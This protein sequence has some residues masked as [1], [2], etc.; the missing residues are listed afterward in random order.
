M[1]RAAPTLASA[2][3]LPRSRPPT[4][5][6]L[7]ARAWTPGSP[8]LPAAA[9]EP[10]LRTPQGCALQQRAHGWSVP[11]SL[12]SG[13]SRTIASWLLQNWRY[14]FVD[15][16][17]SCCH[18]VAQDLPVVQEL[19]SPFRLE[20]TEGHAVARA[21]LMNE[22][23]R[24][25]AAVVLA[26]GQVTQLSL[27]RRMQDGC[28]WWGLPSVQCD[29]C[30][31]ACLYQLCV[32]CSQFLSS[33]RGSRY[34]WYPKACAK[35]SCARRSLMASWRGRCC[36]GRWLGAPARPGSARLPA[37]PP[38]RSPRAMLV[39]MMMIDDWLHRLSAGMA[40]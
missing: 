2:A 3:A 4:W 34:A 36:T 12:A 40:V 35:A 38:T 25:A 18:N 23:G 37:G 6:L 10:V 32:L 20:G 1:E 9:G 27:I 5:P 30:T 24:W 13:T 29:V 15:M 28:A 14:A 19:A 16:S 39:R 11:D 8:G 7:P 31:K 17:K 21:G 22:G 26:A 33:A